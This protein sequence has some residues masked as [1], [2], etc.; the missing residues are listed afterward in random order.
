M[1]PRTGCILIAVGIFFLALTNISWGEIY[2]LVKA[3]G[4]I[5]TGI[6][7]L[8]TFM[9]FWSSDNEA[10]RIGAELTY[11]IAGAVAAAVV[12]GTLL[13]TLGGIP[14]W[15]LRNEGDWEGIKIREFK[16]SV[17][18]TQERALLS[19]DVPEIEAKIVPWNNSEILISGQIQAYST[20]SPQDASSLLNAT[21]LELLKTGE[22]P[23]FNLKLSGGEESLTGLSKKVKIVA[24]VNIPSG[25]ALDLDLKA[26][27]G[28]Y[29][30]DKGRI[31][32]ANL[33]ILSGDLIFLGLEGQELDASTVNGNING[34]LSFGS[35]D[36]SVVNGRMEFI[37]GARNSDYAL[38]TVNG[39]IRM[40]VPASDEL[41]LS[42]KTE[43]IN[44]EVDF[45][46]DDIQYGVNRKE[47][48]M[49]TTNNYKSKSRKIE[50][51]ASTV[52][53]DINLVSLQS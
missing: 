19:W 11:H 16:I 40:E 17:P 46:V 12:V 22:G 52:N 29:E 5:A 36:L 20:V 49:A 39:D 26:I 47:E 7:C 32:T 35:A 48:K 43:V 13:S 23:R 1:N 50:I 18:V 30:M 9:S 28:H 15:Q 4:V 33:E 14:S 10:V 24:E 6:V 37:A 21:S 27:G 25:Q 45:D 34:S 53:G 31:G 51:L 41:G 2:G 42:M 44:G 8:G 38:S 3:Y